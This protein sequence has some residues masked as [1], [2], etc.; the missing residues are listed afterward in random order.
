MDER[1]CYPIIVSHDQ[2]TDRWAAWIAVHE[3]ATQGELLAWL[4]ANVPVQ[5]T[6][7]GVGW[8]SPPARPPR[9]V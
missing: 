6:G 2:E 3:T 7:E 1:E 4:R 5:W 8:A 9:R